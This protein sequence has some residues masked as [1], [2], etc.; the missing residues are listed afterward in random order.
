[1]TGF[2]G[3]EGNAVV[4]WVGLGEEHGTVQAVGG[5][6]PWIE[7]AGVRGDQGRGLEGVCYCRSQPVS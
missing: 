6:D 5:E 4:A 1:M 2:L 7:V 3:A